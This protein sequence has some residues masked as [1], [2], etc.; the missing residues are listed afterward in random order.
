VL[1]RPFI[2]HGNSDMTSCLAL[3][4]FSAALLPAWPSLRLRPAPEGMAADAAR[5]LA[6][7]ADVAHRDAH[8]R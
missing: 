3:R 1:Y 8:Q 4:A 7:H 6:S 2:S 5:V